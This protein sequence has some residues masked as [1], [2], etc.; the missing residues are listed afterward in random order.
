MPI[1]NFVRG[2]DNQIKLTLTEDGAAISGDWD[3]LDIWFGG[4]HLTRSE[5]GDGITLDTSNGLLTLTPADLLADEIA[6]IRALSARES[7][8]VRI[9]LTSV[10]NDDGAVWGGNPALTD[11]IFV[12]SDKPE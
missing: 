7:Y 12:I 1:E 2:G 6:A 4:V 10:V 5:N 3:A 8:R 9:V 11:I